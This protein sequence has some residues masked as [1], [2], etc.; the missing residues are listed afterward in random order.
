MV[1]TVIIVVVVIVVELLL[2][3]L[4]QDPRPGLSGSCFP[5]ALRRAFPILLGAD[6]RIAPLRCPKLSP[7]PTRAKM[8]ANCPNGLGR[9]CNVALQTTQ[10]LFSCLAYQPNPRSEHC[11]NPLSAGSEVNS[12]KFATSSQQQATARMGY[13]RTVLEQTS[14]VRCWLVHACRGLEPRIGEGG[15]IGGVGS[16]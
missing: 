11:L 14:L 13:V 5:N 3:R 15:H 10:R 2:L 9:A 16:Q 7:T 6:V 12:L 4:R 1:R 8:W